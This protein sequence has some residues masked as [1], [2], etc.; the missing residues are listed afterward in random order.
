MKEIDYNNLLRVFVEY[1]GNVV[2]LVSDHELPEV[3]E[4]LYTIE[5]NPY[6]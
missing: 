3:D 1:F 4:D 6:V 2:E 5:P